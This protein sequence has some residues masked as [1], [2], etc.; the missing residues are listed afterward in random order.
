MK[1]FNDHELFS[2]SNA[3]MKVLNLQEI[4]QVSGGRPDQDS[5]WSATSMGCV[6]DTLWST[7]TNDC[8]EH[9]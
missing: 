2:I 6:D 8:H 5:V 7:Q 9:R 1:I 4:E 3:Q